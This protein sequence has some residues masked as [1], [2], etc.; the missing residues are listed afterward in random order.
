[1]LELAGAVTPGDPVAV[2]DKT[3]E[4]TSAV[5]LGDAWIALALVPVDAQGEVLGGGAVTVG[6]VPG[7]VR[8]RV[9]EGVVPPGA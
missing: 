4:I 1:M 7:R 2:A 6:D 5:P 8:R 9:G 3:G